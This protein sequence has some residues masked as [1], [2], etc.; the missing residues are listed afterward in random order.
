[1]IRVDG[2][3]TFLTHHGVAPD[4]IEA[5]FIAEAPHVR[6]KDGIDFV[7]RMQAVARWPDLPWPVHCDTC[8]DVLT[9]RA[10]R[11][12]NSPGRCM[13][14]KSCVR[15]EKHAKVRSVGPPSI[16]PTESDE[17]RMALAECDMYVNAGAHIANVSGLARLGVDA[18]VLS[19]HS[20][21]WMRKEWVKLMD[22]REVA[23]DAILPQLCKGPLCTAVNAQGVVQLSTK[24]F[25]FRKA[26]ECCRE[27]L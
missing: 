26:H 25:F 15:C 20:F 6:A 19:S 11:F 24:F 7:R 8:D 16:D 22:V 23:R 2:A 27:C 12:I 17:I 4:D 13:F 14:P 10:F 5:F 3:K 1:M 9:K 18:S 21:R